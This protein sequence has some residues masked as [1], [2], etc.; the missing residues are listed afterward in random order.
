MAGQMALSLSLLLITG[1]LV[2]GH[3]RIIT[4]NAG[5]DPERLSVVSL[6]PV[7]DGYSPERARELL[8]RLSDRLKLL[9][10]V[11]SA[12]LADG[13][14]M[15]LIG[16][17]SAPYLAVGGDS[18]SIRTARRYTVG[19]EFF[20]TMGIPIVRGRGF[21]QTEEA[22]ESMAAI[23]SEKLARESWPG[24]DAIGRR[25]ELGESD[26]P[27]FQVGGY[28]T[29]RTTA[30]RTR[31]VQVIGVAKDIRDGL[32]VSANDAPSLIYLPLRPMDYARP[33][34][35]GLTIVARAAPG[36]DAMTAVRREAAALDDRVL[37]FSQ[38]TLADHIEDMMSVTRGAAWTYGFIGFFGLVLASVGLGGV[39]AYTVAQRRREIGIRMAI[40]A[41]RV[42][43]MRLV[44]GEGLTLVSIGAALGLMGA[45]AG[46][47]ALAG[48]LSDIAR[49][50]GTTTNDPVLLAGGPL[51]LALVGLAACYLP[52]RESSRID[53]V[54]ALRQE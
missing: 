7:R 51:L 47:R 24:E 12:S 14:P 29:K 34:L 22:D 32:T 42:D 11:S 17:P 5:F 49:T 2:I 25:L 44:M 13:V 26:V 19:R 41:R 36:A 4:P 33:G 46:I 10:A 1:F 3:R 48:F 38:R 18:K 31:L 53:P 30:G 43:V 39:T 20:Q 16:K 6:D 45:R 35:R 15:T 27:T 8:T 52:A 40:G 37:L 54:E 28:R 9:P 50:A 21:R 23:V